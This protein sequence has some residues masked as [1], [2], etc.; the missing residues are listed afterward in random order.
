MLQKKLY[1]GKTMPKYSFLAYK[2][3]YRVFSHKHDLPEL[4]REKISCPLIYETI[5]CPRE[6]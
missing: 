6:S 1:S 2:T 3:L 5:T 4:T